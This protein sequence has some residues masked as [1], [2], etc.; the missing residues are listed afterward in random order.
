V[1]GATPSVNQVR[2]LVEVAAGQHIGETREESVGFAL[3]PEVHLQARGGLQRVG[4]EA[5]AAGHDGARVSRRISPTSARV[6]ST[7]RKYLDGSP[8]GGGG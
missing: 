5:K 4:R 3:D 1:K 2:H 7:G 8:E 6:S